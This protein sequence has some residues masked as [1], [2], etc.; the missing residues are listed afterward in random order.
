M[1]PPTKNTITS[2]NY[3]MQFATAFVALTIV[4]LV[5][6]WWHA[7]TIHTG[8]QVDTPAQIAIPTADNHSP[9]QSKPAPISLPSPAQTNAGA[10]HPLV[11]ALVQQISPPAPNSTA[12]STA[13]APQAAAPTAEN[14]QPA[15]IAPAAQ[16]ATKPAPAPKAAA[17]QQQDDDADDNDDDDNN[18][19]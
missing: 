11:G 14:N 10:E 4:G 19:D 16:P 5:G 6:T 17:K 9:I 12:A 13:N 15:A 3:R 7:H 2:S 8:S 18:S 1:L